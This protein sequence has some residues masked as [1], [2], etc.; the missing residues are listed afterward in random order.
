MVAG[1]RTDPKMLTFR[2]C[3]GNATN[4]WTSTSLSMLSSSLLLGLVDFKKFLHDFLLSSSPIIPFWLSH[5]F[6]LC[7]SFLGNEWLSSSSPPST[8]SLSLL[9]ERLYSLSHPPTQS[10][11]SLDDHS[12]NRSS[13]S[14]ECDA[15]IVFFSKTTSR[16]PSFS[17]ISLEILGRPPRKRREFPARFDVPCWMPERLGGKILCF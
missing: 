5:I 2:N 13:W 14:T 8:A 11:K 15:L 16:T 7:L 1:Y 10:T 9:S 4:T 6:C 3:S 12:V 17:A